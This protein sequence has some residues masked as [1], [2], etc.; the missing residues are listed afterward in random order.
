VGFGGAT[1]NMHV[2]ERFSRVDA[3]TLKYELTVDDPL[4]WTRSWTAV[5]N[6]KQSKDQIYEYACHEGNEA[7]SG[8]LRGER[9]KEKT[10]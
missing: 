6:L 5:L 7:M 9:V 3:E 4:T 2:T 1:A 10:R 8:T